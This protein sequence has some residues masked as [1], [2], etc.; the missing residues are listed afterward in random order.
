MIPRRPKNIEGQS[1][2]QNPDPE[3][4]ISG[5]SACADGNVGLLIYWPTGFIIVMKSS[6]SCSNITETGEQNEK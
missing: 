2:N 6:K 4:N 1:T 3:K 5:R